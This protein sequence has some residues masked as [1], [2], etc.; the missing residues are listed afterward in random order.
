[1]F[2][3]DVVIIGGGPAGLTAGTLLADG[4]HRVLLLEKEDFGGYLKKVERFHGHPDYPQG[5]SGPEFAEQLI[6]RALKSN[7]LME[8]GEAV[9]IESYSG[10]QSVTCA[11]GRHYTSAVVVI[12]GGRRPKKLNVPGAEKFLNKGVIHCVLCDAALYDRKIV[13]VCGGGN[14]GLSDALLMARHAS[15]VIVIERESALT[16][17]DGLTGQAQANGKLEFLYNT[18]IRKINGTQVVETVEVENLKSGAITVLPVDGVVIDIGYRPDT[19]YLEGVVTLDDEARVLVN[20]DNTQLQTDNAAIFAAGDIRSGAPQH[21][22]DAIR[23]GELA[24][25]G[26]REL[27]EAGTH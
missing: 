6:A 14:A 5:L 18:T 24:A 13:V 21:L 19:A 10:C 11:D 26:I 25:A 8:F 2:D 1:M 4:G 20:G 27:L 17:M 3:Q 7:L 23:D 16:A 15:R 22:I 12:A 9:D